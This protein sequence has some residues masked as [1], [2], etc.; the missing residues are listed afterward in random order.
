MK[1]L[2]LTSSSIL[3]PHASPD[4]RFERQTGKARR[5]SIVDFENIP[6]FSGK[7]YIGCIFQYADRDNDG[8]ITVDDFVSAMEGLGRIYSE[9]ERLHCKQFNLIAVINC[10]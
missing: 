9:D 2:M 6:E 5:M 1:D 3:Q 4:C 10:D 8:Y 7:P